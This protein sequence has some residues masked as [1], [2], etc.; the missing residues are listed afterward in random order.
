MIDNNFNENKNKF[1]KIDFENININSPM[2][3]ITEMKDNIDINNIAIKK[4]EESN[5]YLFE[6]IKRLERI[7]KYDI[8][9]LDNLDQKL[10]DMANIQKNYNKLVS[11]RHN[12]ITKKYLPFNYDINEIIRKKI[13]D[14]SKI[15]IEKDCLRCYY[16]HTDYK[17]QQELIHLTVQS[18]N[19]LYYVNYIPTDVRQ[20]TQML[21]QEIKNTYEEHLDTNLKSWFCLL[22]SHSIHN[23]RDKHIDTLE[24]LMVKYPYFSKHYS[25]KYKN[26]YS[27]MI[28]DIT[29]LINNHNNT[30]FTNKI[31]TFWNKGYCITI[32]N[33]NRKNG[34]GF[35]K[36][37]KEIISL[38]KLK[39]PKIEKEAN[40]T[41]TW[42]HNNEDYVL[43]SVF[44]NGANL[45]RNFD[46]RKT[47]LNKMIVK[48]QKLN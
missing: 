33:E 36:L 46:D 14:D 12:P 42:K 30:V 23:N 31:E 6:K 34:N 11:D 38:F 9:K 17:F 22:G 10:K 44:G 5:K 24:K 8:D 18:L 45:R 39:C 41:E 4:L 15:K 2:N 1:F 7:E 19:N 35:K 3:T 21:A 47:I 27:D 37:K 29:Q 43:H 28:E 25:E 20:V 32:R 16:R 26:Q 13:V 48:V 40:M